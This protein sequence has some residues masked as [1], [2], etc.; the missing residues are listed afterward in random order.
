MSWFTP[1]CPVDRELQD[2]L[3]EC[4]LWFLEEFGENSFL[5]AEVILPTEE[6]FPERFSPNE[7]TLRDLVQRV[8]GFMD[9]DFESVE[10]QTFSDDERELDPHPLTPAHTNSASTPTHGGR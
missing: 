7:K 3:E 2:W 9:V 6:F 4:F 1:K 5:D 10:L 8:C